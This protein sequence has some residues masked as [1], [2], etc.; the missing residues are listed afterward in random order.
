[1]NIHPLFDVTTATFSFIVYDPKTRDAIIIDPVLNFDL[2]SATISHTSMEEIKNFVKEHHLSVHLVLDTH[3]HADHMTATYYLKKI[4]KVPSAIGGGF[5][6]SQDYFSNF[7]GL[8]VKDYE[9]AYE[10]LLNHGQTITAGSIEIKALAVPGHTPSC[11]A[12]V[13]NDNV[14]SGD[15]LFQPQLGC[16][17]ADF[18]GGS[19]RDLYHSIKEHL[20]AL[21]DHYTLWVGHDYPSEGQAPQ[22]KSTIL[23]EKTNNR[24]IKKSTTLEQFIEEREKKDKTL[25]TPRLL[26]P[27]LQVNIVGGQLPHADA[28]GRQLLSIP[29]TV[30]EA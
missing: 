22:A 20:Y 16:G 25:G 30:K 10:H 26:L 3:V 23:E 21:P 19:A 29:L 15:T 9:P 14:F 17:R 28:A 27:S 7:Y 24:L 2:F 18:P 4:F 11:T 5:K 13:I 6:K 8:N 1:M 12:Y